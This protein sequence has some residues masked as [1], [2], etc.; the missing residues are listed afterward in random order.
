MSKHRGSDPQRPAPRWRR[1]I[2]TEKRRLVT[3]RAPVVLAALG[4]LTGLAAGAVVIAFRLAYEA[5]QLALL[6]GGLEDF[7]GLAGWQRLLLAVAGAGLIGV[8]MQVVARRDPRTG[9]GFVIER[10][11]HH[12]ARLPLGNAI[13]Q[14]IAGSLAIA[15]GH[16]VGREGPSV[17]MGATAGSQFGQWLRLPHHSLR[18]LIACGTAAAIGASF[19][20]PL[21][22]VAFAMEVVVMEYSIAGFLPVMIAAVTATAMAHVVFGSDIAFSIP[23]LTI[24]GVHELPLVILLGL[25]LGGLA[26]AFIRSLHFTSGLLRGWPTV[27]RA[28]TGGLVVGLL[29]LHVPQIM[30]IGY[31]TVAAALAGEIGAGLLLAIVAAKLIVTAAVLGLGIPGGLVGPTLIMGAT[32]GGAEIGYGGGVV[33]LEGVAAGDLDATDFIF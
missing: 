8:Y 27:L 32:A 11:H 12:Q 28:M 18:T 24:Q 33:L 23:A 5:A 22:G 1:L 20:T 26:A 13:H 3:G 29:A 19:K 17:H 6:P 9:I 2:E 15:S 4:M 31:D 30:G 14:F 10:I 16:S 25:L 21:A 7:E